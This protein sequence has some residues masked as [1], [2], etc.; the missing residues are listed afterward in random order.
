MREG[1]SAHLDFPRG[2]SW[3][4]LPRCLSSTSPLHPTPGSLSHTH[5]RGFSP[6][7]MRRWMTKLLLVRKDRA[8][9][10]QM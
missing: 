2:S 3:S 10:S 7:W 8:Q 6:V 5:C 1:A 4:Q 9:N